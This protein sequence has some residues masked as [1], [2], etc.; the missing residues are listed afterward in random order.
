[1]ANKV[2]SIYLRPDGTSTHNCHVECIFGTLSLPFVYF[3]RNLIKYHCHII[4]L[5][6]VEY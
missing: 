1:M 6:T 2:N 4:G 3:G 5:L